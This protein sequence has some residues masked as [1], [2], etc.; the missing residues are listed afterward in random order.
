MFRVLLFV[1]CLLIAGL[2]CSLLDVR[3]SLFVVCCLLFDVIVR[4]VVGCC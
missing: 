3:R 1:S 2:R 4:F